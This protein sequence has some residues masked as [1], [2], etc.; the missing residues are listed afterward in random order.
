MKQSC[1]LQ[2][3]TKHAPGGVLCKSECV[4]I[5]SIVDSVFFCLFLFHRHL[6][7]GKVVLVWLA[8]KPFVLVADPG[9]I[10]V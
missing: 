9:L 2:N 6:E 10:K 5:F 3:S 1:R 4:G 7:Y 8:F